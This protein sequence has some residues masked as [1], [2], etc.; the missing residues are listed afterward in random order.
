MNFAVHFRAL[1][2]D[3][4][5]RKLVTRGTDV[6]F[7]PSIGLKS[8]Y[9]DRRDERAMSANTEQKVFLTF[10]G[11]KTWPNAA[12][13]L[14]K[15]AGATGIFDGLF[16]E[17]SE[18]FFAKNPEFLQ[19]RSFVEANPKGWGYW[20]WKP[21]LLLKYLNQLR[22]GD[23]IIYLDAGCEILPENRAEF[24]LMLDHLKK[25]G[26]IFFD[27]SDYPIFNLP[28]WTKQSL[29][30]EIQKEFGLSDLLRVSNICAGGL[31]LVK[32]PKNIA[33]L[34]DWYRLATK[35]N[36][37]LIDDTPSKVPQKYLFLA[38]GTINQL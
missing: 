11:G 25:N 27:W 31:G 2:T 1:K 21:F 19:H 4:N 5:G 34:T 36:Y 28:F 8:S 38:I 14:N 6:R 7:Y 18:N 20:I 32:C 33:F 30:D 16:I 24:A 26:T 17:T 3:S 23:M 12:R 13:R 35:D 37:H 22:D 15:Q 9:L 29:L 10:G